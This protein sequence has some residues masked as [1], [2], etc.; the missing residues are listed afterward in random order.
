MAPQ[1]KRPRKV[2]QHQKNSP[3]MGSGGLIEMSNIKM[4]RNVKKTKRCQE[5]KLYFKYHKMS[6]VKK[7]NTLTM[8]EV[9]KKFKLTQ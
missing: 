5:T 4:S 7:S 2:H 3:V 1:T 6:N 9:H 8:D